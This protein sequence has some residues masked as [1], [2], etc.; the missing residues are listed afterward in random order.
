[1]RCLKQYRQQVPVFRAEIDRLLAM[2]ESARSDRLV[3]DTMGYVSRTIATK[4]VEQ[5]MSLYGYERFESVARI[6]GLFEIM[7]DLEGLSARSRPIVPKPSGAV[8]QAFRG[9]RESNACHTCPTHLQLNGH[10]PTMQTHNMGLKRHLVIEF[11]NCILMPRS[12]NEIDKIFDEQAG[13]SAFV[14]AA[15][16]LLNERGAKWQEGIILFREGV[17]HF[18]EPVHDILFAP[19]GRHFAAQNQEHQEMVDML[20]AY[21]EGIFLTP[22]NTSSVEVMLSQAA[23]E[24]GLE[25]SS[26]N[27]L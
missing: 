9:T 19:P 17:R 7:R 12:I 13:K 10:L 25:P 16:V 5:R 24:V 21:Y 27:K 1:M 23:A 3:V 18:L 4:S 26:T 20:A 11:A 6:L 8:W 22:L 2:P 15:Q 14:E